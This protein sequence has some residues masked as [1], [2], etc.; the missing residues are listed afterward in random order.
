MAN[1]G[2]GTVV[3]SL[4]VVLLPGPGL[5]LG[6]GI[7]IRIARRVL[8]DLGEVRRMAALFML[9]LLSPGKKLRGGL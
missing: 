6:H 2:N 5:L 7:L 1:V 3:Q 8:T 4:G 9:M